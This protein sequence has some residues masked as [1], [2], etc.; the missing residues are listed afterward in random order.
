MGSVAPEL[1]IQKL[2]L[3]DDPSEVTNAKCGLSAR[4]RFACDRDVFA[5]A[6]H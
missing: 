3:V 1:A 5:G 2:V 4:D 6:G